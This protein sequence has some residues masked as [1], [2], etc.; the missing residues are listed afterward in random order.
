MLHHVLHGACNFDDHSMH[1][2]MKHHV[3]MPWLSSTARLGPDLTQWFGMSMHS[4]FTRPN[5]FT[6]TPNLWQQQGSIAP[7]KKKNISTSFRVNTP[8]LLQYIQCIDYKQIKDENV[9][10]LPVMSKQD[11][12]SEKSRW[13]SCWRSVDILESGILAGSLLSTVDPLIFP[14]T[15]NTHVTKDQPALRGKAPSGPNQLPGFMN[16]YSSKKKSLLERTFAN[17]RKCCS[18]TGPA[19]DLLPEIANHQGRL[20]LKKTSALSKRPTSRGQTVVIS[21]LGQPAVSRFS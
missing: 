16:K 14:R 18:I 10:G 15:K 21:R 3:E 19:H 13:L 1:R 5:R 4:A 2:A 6:R 12:V 17:F 9:G 11:F 8:V 20:S 7:E